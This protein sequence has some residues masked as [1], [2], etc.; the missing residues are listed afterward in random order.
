[1]QLILKYLKLHKK[2]LKQIQQQLEI[3]MLLK[4]QQQQRK[5]LKASAIE[6]LNKLLKANNFGSKKKLKLVKQLLRNSFK[7]HLK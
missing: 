7:F 6:S 2:I 5:K 1:M 3:G 4:Q